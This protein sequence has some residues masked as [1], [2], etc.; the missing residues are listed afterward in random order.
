MTKKQYS[1]KSKAAKGMIDGKPFALWLN[2]ETQATELVQVE[3][4]KEDKPEQGKIYA[5]TGGYNDK[6]ILN[7]N[8][9]AESIV[10]E[11]SK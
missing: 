4:I 7:G 8:T 3:I 10:T 1:K 6:C 2:P 9:W 5:L 11:G